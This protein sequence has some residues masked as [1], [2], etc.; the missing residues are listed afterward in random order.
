MDNKDSK[1]KILPLLITLIAAAITVVINLYLG[2]EFSVFL[3][4]LFFSI[5]IFYVVGYIAYIIMNLALKNEKDVGILES[6]AEESPEESAEE[7]E[8][9]ELD[10]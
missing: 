8:E 3:K 10:E 7:D 4:R 1:L 5:I 6:E 2:V 9:D